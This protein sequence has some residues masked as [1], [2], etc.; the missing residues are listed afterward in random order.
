M[1][2]TSKFKT[3]CGNIIPWFNAL[4]V[5][6][7]GL[8]VFFSLFVNGQR[9]VDSLFSKWT[10]FSEKVGKTSQKIDQKLSQKTDRLIQQCEKQERRLYKKLLN[11]KDSVI[12]R[13]KLSELDKEYSLL[14]QG[15]KDDS[16][17]LTGPYI[18]SLDSLGIA[19]QCKP[20]E[21]GNKM[22]LEKLNGLKQQF[23]QSDRI[24]KIIQERK[25]KLKDLCGNSLPSKY[26]KQLNKQVY[27]YNQQLK[28]YQG[29][30]NDPDKLLRKGLAVLRDSKMFQEFF[31]KNSQLASLFLMPRDPNDP[32]YI[33]S[34]QGLQ[35]RSQVNAIVQQQIH[36]S[37]AMGQQVFHQNILAA[38]NKMN[39]LKI[40]LGN[41]FQR[42]SDEIMPEGFRPNTQKT[43][44]FFN[45]FE[46]GTNIQT[47]KNTSYFPTTSELGLSLGFKLNDRSTVGL[48][49][50]FKLGLGN[51]WQ[52]LN[53]SAEGIGLRS[54]IDLKLKG[55]IWI[56]G[57]LEYNYLSRI[58]NIQALQLFSAWQKAGLI[59]I[60]RSIPLKTK[61]FKNSKLQLL[62]DFLSYQQIPRTQALICRIN[63]N[64][65]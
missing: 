18:P 34:L 41:S 37:G 55:S 44:K 54:F 4:R 31:R 51:G 1:Y 7:L 52:Q 12:A 49:T 6:L 42:N 50:S 19:L 56:S 10:K 24:R 26:W 40:K 45:R 2:L 38:Q 65:Q 21:L 39:E 60:S 29:L 59:G 16:S 58:R 14:K 35:T 15:L 46:F 25:Q 9:R 28:E 43:K 53:F 32:N 3:N 23:S 57:G 20:G 11:T 17:A 13:K 64:F 36:S 27:Y 5:L 33:N 30:L 22:A 62:W 48:G 8:C 63:Y 61:F 47:Q